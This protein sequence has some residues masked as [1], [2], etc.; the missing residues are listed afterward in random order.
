MFVSIACQRVYWPETST[1]DTVGAGDQ[2]VDRTERVKRVKQLGLTLELPLVQWFKLTAHFL[3]HTKTIEL[4][5]V[6]RDRRT[7]KLLA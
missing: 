6:R 1:C 2:P 7:K 4:G 3:E 5:N